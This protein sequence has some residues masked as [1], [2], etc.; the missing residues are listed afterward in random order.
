MFLIRGDGTPYDIVY[1]LVNGN[2]ILY[3]MIV[4]LLF[5]IYVSMFYLIFFL[6]KKHKEKKALQKGK[7][8]VAQN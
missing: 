7:N 8:Q 6:I 3:P 2:K 4:I 1:N 5:I